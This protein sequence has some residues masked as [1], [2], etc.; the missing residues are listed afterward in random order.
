[1]VFIITI[2]F[3][4]K[5]GRSGKAT[6]QTLLCSKTNFAIQICAKSSTQNLGVSV[7]A[8]WNLFNISLTLYRTLV[9]QMR[10]DS[11]CGRKKITPVPYMLDIGLKEFIFAIQHQCVSCLNRTQIP[12]IWMDVKIRATL[13]GPQRFVRLVSVFVATHFQ[14]NL[15][16]HLLTNFL[17]P[18]RG[19]LYAF[20][21]RSY[22]MITIS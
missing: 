6:S 16:Q 14:P 18:M 15:I 1:M 5:L 7:S 13:S 4:E 19:W 2:K 20:R 11:F 22:N 12:I 3:C 8:V 21:Y 9:T 17:T 10:H